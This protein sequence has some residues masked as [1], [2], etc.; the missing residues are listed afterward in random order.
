MSRSLHVASLVGLVVLLAGSARAD[1]L[2]KGRSLVSVGVS[3]HTGHFVDVNPGGLFNPIYNQESSE[4]GG[5]IA[6]SRFLSD[7]WTLGL[8]GSYFASR[9]KTSGLLG[10]TP[11]E[12]HSFAVRVGGDRYAFVD[13]RVA[14]FAGPGLQF[15][16]ARMK[17][18]DFEP[19]SPYA[20]EFGLDARVG[21]YA[22][23]A[24]STAFFAH[25]GQVV[26]RTYGKAPEGN[27]WWWSSSP[28]GSFGLAFDF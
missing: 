4:V 16:R 7:H 15:T 24:R 3:G 13:D 17:S 11:T 25:V 20:T 22:R 10:F 1:R 19:W 12:T 5:T 6:Y 2:S 18:S 28:E 27:V 9:M 26:S 14:L 21:M 8:S 23:L